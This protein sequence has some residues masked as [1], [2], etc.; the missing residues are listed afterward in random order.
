MIRS[1]ILL[2]AVICLLLIPRVESQADNDRSKTLILSEEM[3]NAETDELIARL[4]SD[5]VSQRSFAWGELVKR[6]QAMVSKLVDIVENPKASF[7]IEDSRDLAARLLAEFRDPKAIPVLVRNVDYFRLGQEPLVASYKGYPCAKALSA[8]GPDSVK[9]IYTH[10]ATHPHDARSR[11]RLLDA[12]QPV[13]DPL[14]DKA[15]ELFAR[16]LHGL[17]W[18]E[19]NSPEDVIKT[20]KRNRD[21]AQYQ[22]D[23]DRVL[24]KMEEISDRYRMRKI[25]RAN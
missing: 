22:Y 13:R 12:G 25:N 11:E 17:H 18:T 16:L 14:S 3:K 15:V 20:V 1:F 5:D 4:E 23:Y 6:R 10:L 8:I 2:P 24:A 21:R 9:G 19:E 7:G